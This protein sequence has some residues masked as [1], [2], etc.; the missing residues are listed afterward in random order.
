MKEITKYELPGFVLDN[1]G[2]YG[3]MLG[4]VYLCCFIN[5]DSGEYDVTVDTVD[6]HGDFA[7]NLEWESYG[8]DAVA[9]I[10]GLRYMVKKYCPPVYINGQKS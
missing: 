10:Q 1:S 6:T 9:T 2:R 7:L 4:G 8:H 3:I 5:S